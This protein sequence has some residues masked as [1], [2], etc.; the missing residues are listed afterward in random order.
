M[1]IEFVWFVFRCQNSV[2]LCP[3]VSRVQ[4]GVPAQNYMPQLGC[5]SNLCFVVTAKSM[6][7]NQGMA[8]MQIVNLGGPELAFSVG[9]EVPLVLLIRM[10]FFIPL[11]G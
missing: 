5:E 11:K 3:K 6:D 10:Y 7:N 1:L 9:L 8:A 2:C 4:V